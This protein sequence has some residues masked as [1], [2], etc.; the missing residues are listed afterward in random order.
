MCSCDWSSD[1]CSSDLMDVLG[2]LPATFWF[3]VALSAVFT[4]AR[5]SEAFLL[6]KAQVVGLPVAFV[7]AV[8]VI[9]NLIYALVAFPAGIFA[10]GKQRRNYLLIFGL[11]LLILADIVLAFATSIA[12]VGVGVALWG[13]HMGC[14]QG[15]LATLIADVAPADLRGTAFG[16]FNLISGAAL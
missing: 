9:M 8:L 12:M 14:T 16:I 15:L 3:V 5:F 13:L 2:K 10:Q 1:V 7:P 4:L 6:L 11:L